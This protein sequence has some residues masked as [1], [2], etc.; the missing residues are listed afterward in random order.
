MAVILQYNETNV[1]DLS[2][3]VL[4]IK[5]LYMFRAWLAHPQQALHKRN[6]VW[7]CQFA[8]ARLQPTDITR[9]QYTKFHCAV[10]RW[11]SWLR[12]C[13]TNRKVAGSIPD[14]IIGIFNWH[15]P[16]GRTMAL[17]LTQPLTEMGTRYISW[18]KGS[19]WIG[20]TTLPPSCADCLKIWEPQPSGTLRVWQGL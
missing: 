18:G 19:R 3:R 11:C 2:F 5:G 8:V 17:G 14:G 1:M 15:N 6:L 4:R 9:T 13:A 12:H 20:L 7:V 10:T 16:S